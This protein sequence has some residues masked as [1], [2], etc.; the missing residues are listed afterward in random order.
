METRKKLY[1]RNDTAYK[2]WTCT[3][4][5][6]KDHTFQQKLYPSTSILGHLQPKKYTNHC[7][8]TDTVTLLYIQRHPSVLEAAMVGWCTSQC[9]RNLT[10]SCYTE[11]TRNGV[12]KW[13]NCPTTN[14]L[15]R[16]LWTIAL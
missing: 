6:V 8:I 12:R 1:L 10:N 2:H 3:C 7:P 15:G 9:C 4:C 13:V 16:Y 5:A 14:T 11:E